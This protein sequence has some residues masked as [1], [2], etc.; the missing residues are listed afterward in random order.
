MEQTIPEPFTCRDGHLVIDGFD[1]VELVE[2]EGTPLLLT[3][4]N[5]IED[6]FSRIWDAFSSAHGNVEIK[7]ALKANSNPSVVKILKRLGCGA[8]VSSP[9]ELMLAQEL[10]F[11]IDKILYSPNNSS[12]EDL[13]LGTSKNITIN[14]DSISQMK[15]VSD[16]LPSRISF[17]INVDL[18]RGE[19]PGTTT[20]GPSAK[21][22]ISKEEALEGYRYALSR[23]V[24]S[25]G[26]HVMTGSNIL[27]PEHFGNV[28]SK[29]L[30]AAEFISENT[31]IK[32]D[33]ADIGGGFGVPYRPGEEK[34]NIDIAARKVSVEFKKHVSSGK[35][36]NPKLFLEPGRYLVADSSVMLG[37]VNDVKKAAKIFVGTDIGMNIFLRPALYG[38]YHNVVIANDLNRPVSGKK[39]IVGQICESTDCLAR[40]RPFPEVAQGDIIAAFNA[41]AYVSSM[42]SNYNGRGR[43]M[44]AMIEDGKFVVT[45]KRDS[46][47]D[48]ISNYS[49]FASKNEY[50]TP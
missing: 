30:Q 6:N 41:G 32:F 12:R 27:D 2:R 8:D 38:A 14:F 18:E 49:E 48:F 28:A 5:R 22:G 24:E 20:S 36:G 45:R 9:F 15:L 19:F 47:S 37:R 33:F 25:F 13:L 4:A 7:Y 31:G 26:I 29:L 16:V 23:G 46:F 35:I 21:F 34:L 3:S 50:S 1:V 43:P 39:D 44:E 11:P 10:G 40:D 17:R 42:S